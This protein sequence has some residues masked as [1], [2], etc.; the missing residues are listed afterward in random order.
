MS[1]YV[2]RP[3]SGAW[4]SWYSTRSTCQLFGKNGETGELRNTVAIPWVSL[5]STLA[6]APFGSLYS[7]PPLNVKFAVRTAVGASGGSVTDPLKRTL[8]TAGESIPPVAR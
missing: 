6:S 7:K 2:H 1:P 4:S 3:G 8:T 5:N